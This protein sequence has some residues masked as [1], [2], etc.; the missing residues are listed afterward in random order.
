MLREKQER[1]EIQEKIAILQKRST[2]MGTDDT[3]SDDKYHQGLYGLREKDVVEN[4]I[5]AEYTKQKTW[6]HPVSGRHETPAER[7]ARMILYHLII[8]S[9][10]NFKS[11]YTGELVGDNYQIVRNVVKYGAPNSV[12]MKIDLTKRLGNYAKKTD[13]G[14]QEYELGLRTLCDEL[15]AVGCPLQPTDM[16]LRL[17][18][19]MTAD[20]RYDKETKEVSDRDESYSTCHHVFMQKAQSIGNLSSKVKTEEANAASNDGK[21]K[22]KGGKGGKGKGKGKGRG[23][24]E[25]GR[26]GGRG[27]KAMALHP[28]E[29]MAH[30][31]PKFVMNS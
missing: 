28:S 22:G 7:E 31:T 23:N 15:S 13:Q 21:E 17:I 18:V 9:L 1:L 14:Y 20:K 29:T 6:V 5:K 11:M 25:G 30:T 8:T 26:G 2:Q 10:A 3:T 19:G 16:T 12:R 27:G 4:L 24:G